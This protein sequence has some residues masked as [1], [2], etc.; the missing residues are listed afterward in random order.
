MKG[1]FGHPSAAA[2]GVSVLL[3]LCFSQSC[4]Q[5]VPANTQQHV[6][7][8]VFCSGQDLQ[9]TVYFVEQI[10][11]ADSFYVPFYVAVCFRRRVAVLWGGGG[12]FLRQQLAAG[13]LIA[14]RGVLGSD[15]LASS[16]AAERLCF[17]SC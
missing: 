9:L 11:N 2:L 17:G 7:G 10:P 16:S 15:T 12:G 6:P 13:S 5:L 1:Y 4:R 3:V 14:A 8:L